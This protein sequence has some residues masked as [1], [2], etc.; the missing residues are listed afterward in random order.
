M[1]VFKKLAISLLAANFAFL[2]LGQSNINEVYADEITSES[3][4]MKSQKENLIYAITDSI[5]VKSTQSYSEYA[6][7][8]TRLAYDQ[9]IENARLVIEKGDNA[10]YKELQLATAKI[11]EAKAGIERDV[12]RVLKINALKDLL[13]KNKTAVQ[14]AKFLL[15]NAPNTVSKVKGELEKQIKAA[16][17]II[18]KTEVILSKVN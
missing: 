18:Q 1:K 11:N 12:N 4:E 3:K 16:E 6:K 5:N 7:E 14:S 13:E 8:A 9:A 15:K 10:T 2:G 17:A